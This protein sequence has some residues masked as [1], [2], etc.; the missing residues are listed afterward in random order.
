MIIEYYAPVLGG[1]LCAILCKRYN[2]DEQVFR[3]ISGLE[4]MY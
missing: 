2:Q 3:S 1:A 4:M